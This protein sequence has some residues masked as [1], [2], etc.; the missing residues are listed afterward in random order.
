ML[1]V[2]NQSGIGRNL[3]AASY[4]QS[5]FQYPPQSAAPGV[6]HFIISEFNYFSFPQIVS[7]LSP[8]S[9]QMIA[10]LTTYNVHTQGESTG[11][12]AL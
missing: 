7:G 3:A 8:S 6:K 9:E 11:R 1:F 5:G 2:T 10:Y 4:R 12:L